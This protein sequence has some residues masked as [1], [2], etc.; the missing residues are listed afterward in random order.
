MRQLMEQTTI[1]TVKVAATNC[2]CSVYQQ[3]KQI[4]KIIDKLQSLK[5]VE[6]SVAG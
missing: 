3:A 5:G 4:A 6:P 1:L 2:K